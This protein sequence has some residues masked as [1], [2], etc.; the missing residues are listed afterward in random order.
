MKTPISRYIDHAVLKPEMTVQEAHNAIAQGIAYKVKTVCV[1]PCDIPMAIQLCKGSETDVCCVLAFP[2]GDI[3]TASK[4]AEAKLYI[5]L[6]VKEIDMVANYGHIRSHEW[7]LVLQDIAAVAAIAKRAGILLKVIVETAMLTIS[8][9]AKTTEICVEAGADYVKTSTGFNGEGATEAGVKAILETAAGRILVKASGGIRD[10][11]R[12]Q[13]FIDMGCSRLGVGYNSTS[14][15][16]DEK[17]LA[18]RGGD[19]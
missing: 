17:P 4:E 15:I 10:R 12:A 16:C 8:E 2:H 13:L 11:A 9:I 1:R 3:P 6:G 7:T 14:V 19:Y 18:S 5:V